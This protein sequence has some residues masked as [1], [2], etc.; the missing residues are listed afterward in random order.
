MQPKQKQSSFEPYENVFIGNFLYGLGLAIGTQLK[1]QSLP[2][3]V[4][5]LQQTPADKMLGDVLVNFSGTVLLYEFKRSQGDDKKEF[6]KANKLR[7]V[8]AENPELLPVSRAVHWYVVSLPEAEH[9]DPQILLSHYVDVGTRASVGP[10][11]LASY[12][13]ALAE[14]VLNSRL[15]SIDPELIKAYL[16]TVAALSDIE[17]VSTGGMVVAVDSTGSVR[18]TV[19]QDLRELSLQHNQHIDRESVRQNILQKQFDRRLESPS[20]ERKIR[21]PEMGR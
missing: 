14:S 13:N 20:R 3:C 9:A 21:T 10:Q 6:D 8:L 18:Y 15:N 19:M 2:S 12:V 16:N 4:S 5:L 7:L 1:G 11:F 17:S